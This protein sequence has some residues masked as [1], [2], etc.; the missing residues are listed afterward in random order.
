MLR[1]IVRGIIEVGS[2][3]LE[4][5]AAGSDL[6]DASTVNA[7]ITNNP[8]A[9][10]QP[11]SPLG[12]FSRAE[13]DARLG[14]VHAAME[15]ARLDLLVLSAPESIFY[16]SGYRSPGLG[17]HEYLLV[18]LDRPPLF[19]TRK[20]DVGNLLAI[21]R[22]T[23]IADHAVYV[24]HH[25]DPMATLVGLA[26]RHRLRAR[27]V[28]VEKRA[29]HLTV[30]HYEELA[31]AFISAEFI[32]AS[33]IVED[34]RLIKSSAEIAYHRQAAEIVVAALRAGVRASRLGQLDGSVAATI[35]RALI[36]KGSEWV[37]IWPL[38]RS[39]IQSGR[40]HSSWQNIPIKRGA[41]TNLETAGVVGRYHTPLYRTVIHRPSKAQRRIADT[42]RE[43]NRAAVQAM[44]P[45]R[46]ARQIWDAA[47]AVAREGGCEPYFIGRTGYSVG[48]AFSP[49]WVQRLGID[50]T[51]NNQAVLLPGMVFHMATVFRDI[52]R[53]GMGQSSTVLVTED[54]P[55][56]LTRA[57]RPGPILID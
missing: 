28:G 55:E 6:L 39:G 41:P 4:T 47:R 52:N 38:V 21:A 34:L 22:T 32:D 5:A 54:G 45:G 17:A 24:D 31:A 30:N 35:A 46:T 40:G 48:I 23:P 51:R 27:R 14:R 33:Q 29:L 12:V 8:R 53:W 57:M 43:T 16:V 10:R 9:A 3:S 2:E 1:S 18:P 7:K 44:R 15:L 20:G 37:S 49:T 25:V 26:R 19:M 56:D 42:L 13:Y 50:I 36:R 11:K